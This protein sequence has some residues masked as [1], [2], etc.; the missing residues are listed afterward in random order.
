M[1]PLATEL[2]FFDTSHELE[3]L[4]PMR[5]TRIALPL[6][7]VG[8]L[9]APGSARA[10]VRRAQLQTG[11]ELL[12]KGR[13]SEALA[14]FRRLTEQDPSCLEAWNNRAALEAAKG[15]LNAANA[16][17][18]RAIEAHPNLSMIQRNLGK[19]RSRLAR[20]AYDS[21]FGTPSVLGPL[22]LD[23][24]REVANRNEAPSSETARDSLLLA[25]ESLR[26]SSRREIARR[27]SL[28]ASESEEIRRLQASLEKAL[29]GKDPVSGSTVAEASSP[30]GTPSA[31]SEAVS[32]SPGSNRRESVKAKPSPSR[33]AESPEGVVAALE[34]WAKAWSDQ[35]ADAYL[36]C[37]SSRFVPLGKTDRGTWETYRRERLA[38]PKSI[39]VGISATKVRMLNNHRAEVSFRQSYQT[40]STH[41]LSRKRLEFAWEH[42]AWKISAEKEAR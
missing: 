9:L 26:E 14:V 23:L 42:G 8:F 33:G 41:L 3:P 40:E 35:D 11:L 28:L 24:Q 36:A 37:Y 18:E 5:P 4:E 27:D 6:L 16:S 38:S 34:N 17:L 32:A 22:Q 30:R 15:D 39:R 1:P 20:L 2:P 7:A 31:G 13:E 25:M 10:Q 21:A 19:V 29:T 12:Q